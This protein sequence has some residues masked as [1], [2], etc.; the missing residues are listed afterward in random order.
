MSAPT[1]NSD[2]KQVFKPGTGVYYKPGL[3]DRE[4]YAGV[5]AALQDY[6]L[7]KGRPTRSYPSNW[8]G[9]ISAIQNMTEAQ[10]EPGSSVGQDPGTGALDPT[11]GDWIET[12]PPVEGTLWF[13]TRQGRL[14][15]YVS[16]AWVQTNGGDGF[17]VLTSNSVSPVF[18]E[19]IPAPGQFWYNV[20][21]GSLYIHD[22]Q[23]IDEEGNL[24]PADDVESFPISPLWRLVASPSEASPFTTGTTA[25]NGSFS[26]DTY[27]F[28]DNLVAT[29]FANQNDINAWIVDA[30]DALDTELGQAD[31]IALTKPTSPHEGELWFDN[32]NQILKVYQNGAWVASCTP[33]V[34]PSDIAVL[35]G[36][37]T[38]E[39]ADRA[40]AITTLSDSITDSLASISS[41]ISNLDG[42]ITALETSVG[43]IPT[44]YTTKSET[45]ALQSSLEAQI[46]NITVAPP[47]LSPYALSSE[48]S[49]LQIVV[50]NLP[51]QD[52]LNS[53]SANIP[54]VSNFV[55]QSHIDYSI[56]EASANYMPKTGGAF[57]GGIAIQRSSGYAIDLSGSATYSQQALRMTSNNPIGSTHAT[58]GANQEYWELAWDLDSLED[59]CVRANGSKVFSANKE[60]IATNKLLIGDFIT[61]TQQG[62]KMNNTVDVGATLAA[63]ISDVN[64]LKG[65]PPSSTY[66]PAPDNSALELLQQK[67]TALEVGTGQLSIDLVNVQSTATGDGADIDALEAGFVNLETK[68]TALESQP[69]IHYSDNAPATATDGD[70]WFQSDTMRLLVRHSN[71]WLNPDRVED[72]SHSHTQTPASTSNVEADIMNIKASLTALNATVA[73]LNT[74]DFDLQGSMFH[75]I[76][77]ATTFNELKI[78]LM[79]ALST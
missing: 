70:L 76:S 59:L 63:L 4:S 69:R 41:N 36:T 54:D 44:V 1:T 45:T 64:V 15:V 34:T 52:A 51:D 13:D 42:D 66:T 11:T 37:I 43:S 21:S 77:G 27:N 2:G 16:G 72:E 58:F 20:T 38:T 12:S 46:N 29:N 73:N 67:V 56:N 7:S 53:V 65:Q 5:I 14:L 68:V 28:V 6:E 48:L 40:S 57:T 17:P 74:N 10:F 78:R 75:A 33:P 18:P 35:N 60:G 26:N 9:M 49:N 23:F 55:Y 47:D 30:V 8:A 71:A 31:T 25:N 19:G 3:N 61:N 62:R 79:T 32:A 24:V 50:G 22:G 39:V